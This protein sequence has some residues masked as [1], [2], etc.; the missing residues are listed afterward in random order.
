MKRPLGPLLSNALGRL[1][2]QLFLGKLEMRLTSQP[3]IELPDFAR[4]DLAFFELTR[5]RGRVK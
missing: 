4:D 5:S 1:P 3:H 2:V